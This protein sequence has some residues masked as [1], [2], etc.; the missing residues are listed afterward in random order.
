M[1]VRDLP[2][3]GLKLIEPRV[4][5][6]SRGDFEETWRAEHYHTIGVPAAADGVFVQDNW[7]RSTGGTLRGLHYQYPHSQGKLVYVVTGRVFDV[8]LDIRRESPTFG[9]W[10]GAVLDDDNRH[11]LYVPP[12]FA[13]GFLVLSDQADFAYKCTDVYAPEH[14]R[15]VAWNDADLN[16]AWPE[17]EYPIVSSE[18]DQ[19]WPPL[20]SIEASDLPPFMS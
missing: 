18:R 9:Q 3:A 17:C 10:Y 12:G 2:L 20:A 8:A 16:I 15:G 6:D 1:N 7:S 4:F 5:S 19:S 11:Q 14:E 13:H